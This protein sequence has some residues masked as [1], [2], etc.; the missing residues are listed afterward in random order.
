MKKI[1]RINREYCNIQGQDD[2]DLVDERNLE[3]NVETRTNYVI[4]FLN[5][6]N[7][8]LNVNDDPINDDEIK[9]FINGEINFVR[10]V[11]SDDCDTPESY[12]FETSNIN[13]TEKVKK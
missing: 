2:V 5:D 11:I 3:D 4:G 8:G 9:R 1:F 13:K 7:V 6:D 12:T 10:Y